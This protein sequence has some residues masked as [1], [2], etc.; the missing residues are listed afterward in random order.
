MTHALSSETQGTDVFGSKPSS[1]T[2]APV[3]ADRR[4]SASTNRQLA[5]RLAVARALGRTRDL[6][7]V[8]DAAL[9]TF[10][11]CLDVSRASILLFDP[12]GV[13]RFKAYR[14]LSGE[15]RSA[16]QGHSPWTPESVDPEPILVPDVTR[17]PSLERYLPVFAEEGIAALAFVPLVSV[18]RVIGKFMLYYA[19]PHAFE[20]EEVQLAVVIASAVAF[21]VERGLAGEAVRRNE[22]SPG[23]EPAA[24]AFGTWE[25]EG[26]SEVDHSERQDGLPSATLRQVRHCNVETSPDCMK[27]L[28]L[29]GRLIYI[30]R[31]GLDRLGVDDPGDLLHRPLVDLWQDK[32]RELLGNAI[33]QAKTGA[34]GRFQGPCRTPA[35][36]MK[37][38]DMMIMPIADS[39]GVVVQLLAVSR[40]VSAQWQ[41]ESF[42]AGQHQVL[43]MVAT[44]AP[45]P[46]VLTLLVHVIEDQCDGTVCSVLLLDQ[47]GVHARV[48]AAPSLPDEYIGRIDG[49]PVGPR[50]GSCGSVIR[51]GRPVIVSDIVGDS[52]FDVLGGAAISSGLRACWSVPILSSDRKVLGSFAMYCDV[53]RG[54]TREELQLVETAADLAGAAI[55]HDR[56][57]E[58]L[59]QSEE[60][61]RAILR[62][63]PDWMFVLSREGFYLDCHIKNP[64]ALLAR[65]E[66]FLGKSMRDILP[67]WLADLFERAFERA[68]VTDEPER[69]EYTLELDHEQRFYEACIVRCDSDK[70]LAI[71]RDISDRKRAELDA[72]AQRHE[73]AHLNRVLILAEQSGALAHELS[74]PLAAILANAQAARHLLDREPLDLVELR[75]TLDDVIKSDKRAGAVIH[76]LRELL[77]KS[78]TILQ[79]LD[80][81]E[82]IREVLDLTHSDLLLRRVSIT[83]ALSPDIPPVLGDRVQL[84]QVVLNVL[85]NA[86]DA[87]STVEPS[88]RELALTTVADTQWVQIVVADRGVGIPDGELDSVF[89]PFVTHRSQ[90][91][92]LGLAISRSI[93]AAHRG[94]IQAEN[95]P[96]RGATFRCFLPLADGQ[97]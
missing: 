76:R 41:A 83:T 60:R 79:P 9:D 95:N 81:N 75:E 77:R 8:Y 16:V 42:Q 35:G 53:P 64:E 7:D 51:Q 15:Y 47:D 43:E 33:A 72:A 78:K 74:Q 2:S 93:V 56:S 13:M 3:N 89:D 5:V 6:E 91:L 48:G 32:E 54:P 66:D 11:E 25:W 26:P 34:I 71:V 67:S 19:T 69:L 37:W 17:E 55:D 86:C 30:N 58:A 10:A 40:D 68:L 20:I 36:I 52:H 14:G 94:R 18:G 87:M 84:Q 90:G 39:R 92:G 57:S 88:E 70:L 62:A 46:E 82:V 31:A 38:W 21:A 22:A 63:I 24:A 1:F 12:D 85:L 59:R 97:L 28:D 61:S 27:I 29:D 65:P 4:M 73:L 80:V 96:D 45:L 50:I 44:G 23:F 49:Q